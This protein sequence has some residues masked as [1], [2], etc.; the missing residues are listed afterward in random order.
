MSNRLKMAEQQAILGL[1][2]LGWS[3]RRIAKELGVDRDTVSRHVKAAAE[4]EPANAEGKPAACG[5]ELP[6]AGNDP[7]GAGPAESNAAIV[8]TGSDAS[9]GSNAAI[10]IT[11]CEGLASAS[12][13]RRSRC[14]PWRAVI[15][16]GLEQG[17]TAKRIWQDLK[18]DRGFAGD[19]QSVQRFACKL[20]GC[21]PS[22]WRR[23]ECAPGAE[24]QVDFGRG[25][26]ILTPDGRRMRPHLFRIVLSCSRKAYSEVVARQTTEQFIRCLENAFV[27][28]GGVPKTL[29]IDNLKAAVSQADWYDP[30]LNPKVQEFA[31]HYGTV[32]VPTRPYT[33][34]HKGKIE[35]QIGYAQSNALKGRTFNSLAEQ[36][37]FLA[38]WETSVADTRIHGTTRKQVGRAFEELEKPKLLPLPPGR[39]PCFQEAQRAVNRDG[40]VEVAKAYYSAPPEF[41]GRTV[42]A[43]WDGH[44]VRLFDQHLRQIAVHAQHEPGRFATD[45]RHIVPEKRGGIERGTAWWMNKAGAIGPYAGQWAENALQSRGIHALRAVMGLVS[46]TRRHPAKLIEQACQTAHSHGAHRLRDVRNLLKRSESAAAGQ[47]LEFAAEH[48][49]IRS[50]SDYSKLVPTAFE[51]TPL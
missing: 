34:R 25:A 36:N 23:M 43:R 38:D 41:V 32:V 35:R 48:P 18:T 39:F 21:S 13:G 28:F 9:S 17:L 8:M 14:E 20:K 15:L 6:V 50:L 22:P 11:G 29:I 31:R 3:Y 46:L 40:H 30:E 2:R 49:L 19:Y 45:D 27:H 51:R 26:P 37:R 16:Q 24:A 42:W 7:S 1:A 47:Q 33:P 5:D 44:V 4:A 12:P 10:S